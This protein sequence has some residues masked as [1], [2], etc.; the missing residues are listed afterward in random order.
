MGIMMMPE[1]FDQDRRQDPKRA[2]EAGVYDALQN[3][4]LDGH[5]LYEFRHRRGG[6]EVDFALW[7]N[8]L[9][10]F[11]VQVK[12]G[13]YHLDDAGRWYLERPDGRRDSV[14]S[15]LSATVDGCMEM[16]NGIRE[17]TTYSTFVVGVLIFPDMARDADMERAALNHKH[18]HIIWGLDGLSQELRRIATEEETITHPP[19]PGHSRNEWEALNR[20]QYRSLEGAR[21][22]PRDGAAAGEGE[23]PVASGEMPLSL[24]SA[25]INIQHVNTLVIQGHP[26]LPGTVEDPHGPLA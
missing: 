13:R 22:R 2:A 5:G 14:G 25:T 20:V 17:S 15:P 23:A 24:G 7:L 16:R 19:E 8:W 9:A 1:Q 6:R 18:V 4:D 12:G 11:A 26:V 3:L 10:R 21:E